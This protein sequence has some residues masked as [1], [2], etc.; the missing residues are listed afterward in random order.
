MDTLI[1]VIVPVYNVEKYLKRCV[2]SIQKQTYSYLQ[3]ILVDDGS[4]DSSGQLCDQLAKSDVRLK[5][6]HKEN[7]GLSSARNYGL[8]YADG[9]VIAFVDSDDYIHPKMYEQMMQAMK[10]SHSDMVICGF[11]EVFE[12]DIADGEHASYERIS[13]E[14]LS[15]RVLDI[16]EKKDIPYQLKIRDVQTV[17]QWNKLFKRHI[18]E[19]I[20]YPEGKL[21]EDVF[22]IHRE[23]WECEKIAYLPNSYYYYVQRTNSIMH[24]VAEKNLRDAIEGYEERIAF[25]DEKSCKGAAD[26]AVEMLL[27]YILWKY[28]SMDKMQKKIQKWLGKE[29]RRH[30]LNYRD[31]EIDL[32]AYKLPANSLLLYRMDKK[33][34]KLISISEFRFRKIVPR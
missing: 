22:V 32:D 16:V 9:D 30:Y 6:L 3:I 10:E 18:F 5:V 15:C 20:R 13:F 34:K 24:V 14:D 11:Q 12:E 7:G 8:D 19:K 27:A 26:Q 17:V 23:L 29:L 21:H 4:T 2:A 28:D 33:V 1:S 31:R 25:Y